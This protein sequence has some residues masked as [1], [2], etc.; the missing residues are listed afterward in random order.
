M[1][2]WTQL[3]FQRAEFEQESPVKAKMLL[4]RS[5]PKRPVYLNIDLYGFRSESTLCFNNT[6]VLKV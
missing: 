4:D 1:Y 5:D 6:F 3:Y 2:S